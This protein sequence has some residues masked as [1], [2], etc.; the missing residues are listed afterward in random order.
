MDFINVKQ[1]KSFTVKQL[2]QCKDD[3]QADTRLNL[4]A[5]AAIYFKVRAILQ[6]ASFKVSE[7]AV[8]ELLLDYEFD[9]DNNK[10]SLI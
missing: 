3:V 10:P 5:T 9:G 8:A 7:N 1:R 6:S 2:P 4:P